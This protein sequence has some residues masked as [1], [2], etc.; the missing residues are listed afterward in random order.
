MPKTVIRPAVAGDLPSILALYRVLDEEMV[1]LQP[2]FFCAAPREEE[3]ILKFIE[4]PDADFLLAEQEG[5]VVG[6]A[7]V[8]YAGWTPSFSC[9]LP[10]R[11]ASLYDLVVRRES[12]CQGIGSSLLG[13]SKRWARDR[14]LEYLEL[15]VLAQN[16]NAIELYEAHDFVE[17][18]RTMRCML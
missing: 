12:R 3:P 11:Y 9:V 5:I 1:D 17:A 15:G 14:R 8:V 4:S 13:A 16:T 10:H 2:E 18:R 7:L 6:L